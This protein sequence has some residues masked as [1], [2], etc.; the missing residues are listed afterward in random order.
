[1]GFLSL[2]VDDRTKGDICHFLCPVSLWLAGP[3]ELP[4]LLLASAALG[5]LCCAHG[6]LG[7]GA[8]KG[9]PVLGGCVWQ[10]PP[11]I[12]GSGGIEAEHGKKKV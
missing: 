12:P 3:Q 4:G 8:G 6:L 7:L 1:M 9:R 5:S 11:V 2:S 10:P